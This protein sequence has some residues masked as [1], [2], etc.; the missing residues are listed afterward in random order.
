MGFLESKLRALSPNL[1]CMRV[2]KVGACISS[3]LLVHHSQPR[4]SFRPTAA[5][6][7]ARAPP[8][9]GPVQSAVADAAGASAGAGLLLRRGNGHCGALRHGLGPG[10]AQGSYQEADVSY[11]I[12]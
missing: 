3:G 9:V 6:V 7:S 12:P 5:R 1:E 4:C 10:H 2:F 11:S 8:G